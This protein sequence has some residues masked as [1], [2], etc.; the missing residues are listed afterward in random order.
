MSETT[1]LDSW[2]NTFFVDDTY[3]DNRYNDGYTIT[4]ITESGES[5]NPTVVMQYDKG[6]IRTELA[7]GL[8]YNH[9]NN[10]HWKWTKYSEKEQ[11]TAEMSIPTDSEKSSWTTWFEKNPDKVLGEVK[12]IK[13][14]F[15]E[16]F[17]RVIGSVDQLANINVD[18]ID[19]ELSNLPQLS[20]EKEP[21]NE[22]T[23]SESE[24]NN[25]KQN[26]EKSKKVV[27]KTLIAQVND[28]TN[29]IWSFEEIDKTYNAHLN[30]FEKQAYVVYL[31]KVLGKKVQGGFAKYSV[32]SS[33]QKLVELMRKGYLFYDLREKDKR[34]RYQPKFMFIAG[35]VY[36]KHNALM[37]D[38]DYYIDK[39]GQEI[40]DVHKQTLDT[41][42]KEKWGKA[43][44]LDDVDVKKR[45]I[46]KPRSELAKSTYISSF[47]L[48]GQRFPVRKEGI[49]VF[50][51]DP[52]EETTPKKI[53]LLKYPSQGRNQHYLTKFT[54]TEGFILWLKQGGSPSQARSRGIIYKNGMSVQQIH[55]IYIKG[56]KRPKDI[57]KPQWARMKEF[58][59]S[60]AQTLFNQFLE[61]GINAEDRRMIELKWNAQYNSE[62]E[63]DVN[64]V[65]IGFRTAKRYNGQFEIDIRPEKRRAVAYNMING[66]TMLAY[67]V[68]LGKTWCAIFTLAQNLELGFCKK[69]L[70]VVPNQVYPQFLKEIQAILPQYQING[71]Y[72]MRGIYQEQASSIAENSITIA[73]YQALEVLGFS[74]VV[75]ESDFKNRLQSILLS[76]DQLA[77]LSEKQRAKSTEKIDEILGK[78]K[79]DTVLDFDSP[80]LNYDYLIVDEAHNFK[81]VFTQVRGRAKSVQNPDSTRISYE[82]TEYQISSG[83]PSDRAL[84]LF[85]LTQY[86]QRNNPNGNIVLL[87]AT[88]FTNSPLE[89][90]SIL[91]LL[92]YDYLKLL[93]L[94]AMSDFYDQ[95]SRVESG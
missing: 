24:L 26:L 5:N 57:E 80:N 10:Q 52:K 15:N 59:R 66:S 75:A 48:K 81:K 44:R 19:T 22:T 95:F 46:I 88:P 93:G 73:T 42:Y 89:V 70:I 16:P 61:F 74:N 62:V 9:D 86:I 11:I 90:Y 39:F 30:K 63:L 77:N 35:N 56:G 33:E 1:E 36:Q 34:R 12:Q 92:N 6:E 3:W 54:L 49:Q 23:I 40:Y 45:L 84:K 72:N 87:T 29:E 79:A 21:V 85:F 37:L 8:K 25:L 58:A 43:V 7:K 91:A 60:N 13:T 31:E 68:G 78:G 65:P 4:N 18:F 82:Q 14:K 38:A 47:Y 50:R 69:P 41:V 71:L 17:T 94:S 76:A 55:D 27:A 67:G 83:T 64:K 51:T 32:G 2:N 53:D 28:K 20:V